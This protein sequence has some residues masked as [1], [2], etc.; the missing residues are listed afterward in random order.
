MWNNVY[1]C[2]AVMT[3]GMCS[4]WLPVSR[5]SFGI[6]G[7]L[8][9]SVLIGYYFYAGI[10]GPR[11][12]SIKRTTSSKDLVEKDQWLWFTRVCVKHRYREDRSWLK[13]S[14]YSEILFKMN[15]LIHVIVKVFDTLVMWT[16]NHSLIS[17]V[18]CFCY[19][20]SKKLQQ[21]INV[22]Y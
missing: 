12:G 17:G 2:I 20:L 11:T 13:L 22:K 18:C 9:L 8:V 1:V 10:V 5:W 14:W 21:N 6:L 4:S 15:V 19:K 16:V 7:L 3:G